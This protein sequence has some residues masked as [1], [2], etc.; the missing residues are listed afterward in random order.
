MKCTS[1]PFLESLCVFPITTKVEE[2]EKLNNS[3]SCQCG[4][5]FLSSFF[6]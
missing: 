1:E 3:I 2:L 5:V 4:A 6:F